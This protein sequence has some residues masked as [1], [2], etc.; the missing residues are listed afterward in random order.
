MSIK[1]ASVQRYS[2]QRVNRINLPVYAITPNVTI[3]SEPGIVNYAVNA[4][5]V[6]NSTVLYWTIGGIESA[7]LTANVL[8]GSVTV[9]NFLANFSIAI[10]QDFLTEGPQNLV[11]QLRTNGINGDVVATA[12]T[13][14]VLDTSITPTFVVTPST[15]TMNEG[16][17][18]TFNI[19][20]TNVPDGTTVYWTNAG[21][22]TGP[23]FVSG[24]NSGSF[25][26]TSN[27]ASVTLSVL[28]DATSDGGTETIVFQVRMFSTSGP[29]FATANAVVINDTSF[30]SAPTSIEYLVI[31]GGGGGGGKR[32]GGGGAGGFRTGTLSGLTGNS[33]Y[34]VTIGGG[35]S[36]SGG[37][38]A[39]GG[40]SNIGGPGITE[41]QS[42]GGGG[43]GQGYNSTANGNSGG[44]GG[45]AG[46]T[47]GL[48]GSGGAGTPGQGNNGGNAP[49]THGGAGGGGA[50]GAGASQSGPN[51]G[52]GGSAVTSSISGSSVAYAGGGG[53]GEVYG[54]DSGG[55]G[56][57]GGA[58]AGGD[59]TPGPATANTGSGGG[60]GGDHPN[61]SGGSGGSGIVI[62]RHST[63]QANAT[64][65]GGTYSTSGGYRIYTFTTSGT[66]RFDV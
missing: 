28:A 51:G 58:T 49:N 7:D 37:R 14:T 60:G 41:V 8:N 48:T 46:S 61:F 40:F 4:F 3:V 56:G 17:N 34:V 26:V 5:Y 6:P 30:L 32:G 52:A 33:T 12:P 44:S 43:G 31:A 25:T 66:F 47:D 27:T 16:S 45:G 15:V 64:L 53:G 18:V 42:L 2:N 24:A 36:G 19:T 22:T 13:V 1:L 10:F 55:A 54:G 65:T 63:S 57:G 62:V 23:D 29:V 21:T 59:G 35:G 20:S 9:S 38:G 11:A 39:N 50:G